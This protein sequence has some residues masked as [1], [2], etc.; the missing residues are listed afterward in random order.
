[1]KLD[2]LWGEG[3]EEMMRARA[4]NGE[5]C[6][7]LRVYREYERRLRDALDLPPDLEMK[8]LFENLTAL[9]AN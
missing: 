3:V 2:P 1:M 7:A 8:R 5:L 9:P 4:G 6:R